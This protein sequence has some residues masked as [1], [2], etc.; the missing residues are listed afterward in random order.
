MRPYITPVLR[1]A[2]KK[3]FREVCDGL[4]DLRRRTENTDINYLLL[5]AARQE[6]LYR[7]RRGRLGV[8]KRY[9]SAYLGKG[10]LDIPSRRRRRELKAVPESQRLIPDDLTSGTTLVTNIGSVMPELRSHLGIIEVIPPHTCAIGLAAGRKEPVVVTTQ[11]G[12]DQVA[13]RHVLTVTLIADH[14]VVDFRHMVGFLKTVT[15]CC[16]E[17]ASLIA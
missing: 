12:T 14:R 9:W 15:G 1:Q 8:W 4:T 7:L 5:K 16:R 3:T 17:P 10:R 11:D 13:I 2:G 6:T